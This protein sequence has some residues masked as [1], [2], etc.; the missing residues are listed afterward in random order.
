MSEEWARH[1]AGVGGGRT[2]NR[3]KDKTGASIASRGKRRGVRLGAVV[4]VTRTV[5]PGTTL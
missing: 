3:A 4:V 5:I 2:G 1:D